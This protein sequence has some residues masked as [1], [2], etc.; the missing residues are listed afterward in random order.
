MMMLRAKDELESAKPGFGRGIIN[1]RNSLWE[2]SEGE[3][4]HGN[5]EEQKESQSS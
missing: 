3:R 2:G 5:F 1:R 4:E